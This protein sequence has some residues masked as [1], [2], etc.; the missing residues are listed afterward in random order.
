MISNKV[1][2]LGVLT[3]QTGLCPYPQLF[4]EAVNVTKLT[5]ILIIGNNYSYLNVR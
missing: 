2:S 4:S 5:L 1:C 3:R